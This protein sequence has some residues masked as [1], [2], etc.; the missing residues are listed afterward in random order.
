VF[1]TCS[2]IS[3]SGQQLL[4]GTKFNTH[5]GQQAGAPVASLP[6]SA[7]DSG[8]I[9]LPAGGEHPPRLQPPKHVGKRCQGVTK[10]DTPCTAW[11]TEGGLCYFHANP[12]K[13]SELGHRGGKGK[14]TADGLDLV[15]YVRP[16][17]N[18]DDVTKLLADTINNL[19]SGAM[20]TR[21]ANTVGYLATAML[22]AIQQADLEGRLR[23]VEAVLTNHTPLSRR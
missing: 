20:D 7:S 1:S 2:R 11:A 8:L 15:G 3:A 12:D 22:K 6:A 23:A 5:C 21:I 17:R 4:E 10:N 18:A 14:R 16:L 19:C 9:D 13:A